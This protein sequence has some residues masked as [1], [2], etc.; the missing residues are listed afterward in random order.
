MSPSKEKQS[1]TQ[2]LVCRHVLKLHHLHLGRGGSHVPSSVQFEA[3]A[4]TIIISWHTRKPNFWRYLDL[5]SFYQHKSAAVLPYSRIWACQ[6]RHHFAGKLPRNPAPL[7]FRSA[8]YDSTSTGLSKALFACDRDVCFIAG[9]ERSSSIDK[10]WSGREVYK[11]KTLYPLT[12][13]SVVLI[14]I[15]GW[16]T[17]ANV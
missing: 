9:V 13:N 3:A 1:H 16:Q 6:R 10:H 14:P 2:G 17:S 5:F 11:I 4:P 7:S 8:L 15:T 12:E